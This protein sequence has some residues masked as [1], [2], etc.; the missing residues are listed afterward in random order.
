MNLAKFKEIVP[1]LLI[2]LVL[3]LILVRDKHLP[4]GVVTIRNFFYDALTFVLLIALILCAL[5]LP[6]IVVAV[7]FW[8]VQ[9][10]KKDFIK[11]RGEGSP[12]KLKTVPIQILKV[13]VFPVVSY[14]LVMCVFSVADFTLWMTYEFFGISATPPD[15]NYF[16]NF[17]NYVLET[18]L[19]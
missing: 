13:L 8:W 10:F 16:W 14:L 9:D 15:I 3:A 12:S 17:F 11:W 5:C 2:L 7:L 4:D 6:I 18:K 19:G 1:A